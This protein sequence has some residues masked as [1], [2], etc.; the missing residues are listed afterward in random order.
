QSDGGVECRFYIHFR[1]VEQVRVAGL[2][3][4]SRVAARITGISRPDQLYHLLH[5][6]LLA[7]RLVFPK[8][9]S[10]PFLDADV[11]KDLGFTP[12]TNHRPYLASIENSAGRTFGKFPLVVE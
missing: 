1:G 4:G 8:A 5:K 3:H 11:V 7:G 9:A 10:G 6:R 12:G 2:A